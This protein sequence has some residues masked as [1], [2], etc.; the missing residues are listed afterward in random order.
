ML[1]KW[2]PHVNSSKKLTVVISITTFIWD[3]SFLIC[4]W[5]YFHFLIKS[6]SSGLLSKSKWTYLQDLII[7]KGDQ[8]QDSSNK[9]K[10][11]NKKRFKTL[12]ENEKVKKV[13]WW[14][15]PKIHR[16]WRSWSSSP[17]LRHSC[18]LSRQATQNHMTRDK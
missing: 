3:L 1:I 10:M 8:A 12:I 14:R 4:N 9:I 2:M 13:H 7:S 6:W 5:F 15:N 11:N 16:E 17:K 18:R